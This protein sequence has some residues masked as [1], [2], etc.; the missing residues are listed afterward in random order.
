MVKR[1]TCPRWSGTLTYENV[2][3]GELRERALE[4]T[5]WDH[6]LTSNEF[7]GGARF[8]MGAGGAAAELEGVS[9]WWK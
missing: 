5:I 7:L 8:N 1:T 2:S 6:S 3:L 4:L 9:D